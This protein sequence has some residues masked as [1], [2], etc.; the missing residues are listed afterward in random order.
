MSI[1]LL[2]LSVWLSRHEKTIH[3]NNILYLHIITL[4][5]ARHMIWFRFFPF[6]RLLLAASAGRQQKIMWTFICLHS[7]NNTFCF[8]LIFLASQLKLIFS[9]FCHFVRSRRFICVHCNCSFELLCDMHECEASAASTDGDF[10]SCFCHFSFSSFLPFTLR[11][12]K[13]ILQ[14]E[15]ALSR[16]V[17]VDLDLITRMRN[18]DIRVVCLCSA[19]IA[20]ATAT[21]IHGNH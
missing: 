17:I 15:W 14:N 19:W 16:K 6:F 12:S 2:P 9:H 5:A 21:S 1:R 10:V 18:A 13:N 11:R 8:F 20:C 4:L 3:K 7:F